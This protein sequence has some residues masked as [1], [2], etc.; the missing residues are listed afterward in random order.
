MTH[1]D[2]FLQAILEAP[3]DDTPRLVYADWLTDQDD[4]RGEFIRVQCRLARMD[5]ADPG[6]PVLEAREREL[7]ARHQ[8]EWLGPLCPLLSRGTFRRGFL[9]VVAVPARVYLEQAAIIWP[10]TVRHVEIDLQRFEPPGEVIE[11]VPKSLAYADMVL[12]IGFRGQT[13]VLAIKDPKDE[14]LLDKLEFILNR[15]IEP[16]AAPKQ[17]LL[18]ALRRLYGELEPEGPEPDL[19]GCFVS[20]SPFPPDEV[21][22][23]AWETGSLAARLLDHVVSAAIGRD[24][25]EVRIQSEDGCIRVRYTGDNGTA[26]GEVSLPQ[27]LPP[28]LTRIRIMAGIYVGDQRTEQAGVVRLTVRGKRID[29]GVLIRRL[30]SPEVVLTFRPSASAV[31]SG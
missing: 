5:A 27:L 1:H 24:A 6:R 25:R 16:V 7:L 8:D 10:A 22:F 29:V 17:S 18:E 4:P 30:E 2:A 12:P 11:F 14:I 3:D 15:D 19:R 26:E 31:G 28:L 23:G 20:P 21:D 13:L 9:D